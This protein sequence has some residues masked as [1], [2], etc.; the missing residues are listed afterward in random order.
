MSP[1][2]ISRPFQQVNTLRL[3]QN[4]R[5][6]SDDAFKCIFLHENCRILHEISLK[7]VLKGPLNNITGLVQIMAWCRLGTKLLSEPMMVRLPTQICITRPQWVKSKQ[8]SECK[9][10]TWSFHCTPLFFPHLVWKTNSN[11]TLRMV[12]II[13]YV[14]LEFRANMCHKAFTTLRRLHCSHWATPVPWYCNRQFGSEL[15]GI[16]QGCKFG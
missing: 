4:C 8:I 15:N 1:Y 9:S 12:Q 2:G 14:D 10:I 11:L 5:H 3:R 7:F 16:Y 13:Q 6:F